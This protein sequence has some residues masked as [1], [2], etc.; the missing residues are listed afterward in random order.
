MKCLG[1]R[2]LLCLSIA[3][4]AVTACAPSLAER[5]QQAEKARTLGEGYLG[6]RNVS[7][8]LEQLLEA[9]KL[10]GDDPLIQYDLGLAYFAK[11]ET[12][13][14]IVH[15]QKA[16]A[17]KPDYSEA[18][19]AMGTVYLS[20][21]Q[22]DAAIPLL[23]KAIA[24]LLYATPYYALNNL[25]DAYREKREYGRAIEFYR[26]ALRED[27]LFVEAHRG[28]GLT[29]MAAGDYGAAVSSLEKALHLAPDFAAAR[30]DL[31]IAYAAMYER[32]KAI[33]AFE[34]VIALEPESSLA[35][36]AIDELKKLDKP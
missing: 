29:Y 32:E 10:D 13:M 33:D 18:A 31:G 19:N 24:N 8:A 9:E 11:G 17:L 28:L 23:E 15:L 26:K 21:E 20:L 7:G 5:K 22:W 16:L 4:W 27:P 2:F 1:N 34:K 12:K 3:F 6:E 36:S 14:A 30:F 35:D 25:G